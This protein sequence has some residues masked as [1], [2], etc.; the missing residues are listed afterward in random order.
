[1]DRADL[2]AD[3]AGH[4]DAGDCDQAADHLDERLP[5]SCRT[6][7]AAMT[8]GGRPACLGRGHLL[9]VLLFPAEDPAE[10]AG[11]DQGHQDQAHHHGVFL[12]ELRI[13]AQTEFGLSNVPQYLAHA[14][15]SGQSNYTV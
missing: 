13:E 6:E 12:R 10:Y 7:A 8:S 1:M 3:L 11:Q 2:A 5:V 15:L 14:G 9:E 4:L